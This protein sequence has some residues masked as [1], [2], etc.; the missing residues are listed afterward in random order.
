MKKLVARVLVLLLACIWTRRVAEG[1]DIP[2]LP[3]LH[4]DV[5]A[6]LFVEQWEFQNVLKVTGLKEVVCRID[7]LCEKPYLKVMEKLLL[8]AGL[9]AEQ[10]LTL[11]NVKKITEL[12]F[13][14]N[15]I[16]PVGRVNNGQS[17]PTLLFPVL[18]GEQT[19]H[20]A[21]DAEYVGHDTT[22][23]SSRF[24]NYVSIEDHVLIAQALLKPLEE[25][26][27]LDACH[28]NVNRDSIVVVKSNEE[29]NEETNEGFKPYKLLLKDFEWHSSLKVEDYGRFDAFG[30]AMTFAD[31]NEEDTAGMQTAFIAGCQ[32]NNDVTKYN[33]LVTEYTAIGKFEERFIFWKDNVKFSD[34]SNEMKAMWVFATLA[35]LPGGTLDFDGMA[36]YLKGE[37]DNKWVDELWKVS[38]VMAGEEWASRFVE[39][40]SFEKFSIKGSDRFLKDPF[41]NFDTKYP[42]PV[43]RSVFIYT[44]MFPAAEDELPKKQAEGKVGS[45]V[46]LGQE[47]NKGI[48]RFNQR[49]ELKEMEM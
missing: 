20:E 43:V 26:R 29:T 37:M 18:D 8:D 1:K 5:V 46:I 11:E 32:T 19:L 28:G 38:E 34:M 3:L 4:E 9:D 17:Y 30:L 7:P 23:V 2:A 27:K 12:A 6:G 22:P 48:L 40:E 21:L 16:I 47:S 31:F 44:Y 39:S 35:A 10:E 42:N 25:L 33:K 13:E 15:W 49:I 24:V 41:Y 14:N 45:M 36:R